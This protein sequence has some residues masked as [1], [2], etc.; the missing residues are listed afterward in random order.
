MWK[1]LPP[2]LPRIYQF[3]KVAKQKYSFTFL[4]LGYSAAT[5]MWSHVRIPLFIIVIVI[6]TIIR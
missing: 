2:F 4:N 5:A 3:N 1:S 6:S